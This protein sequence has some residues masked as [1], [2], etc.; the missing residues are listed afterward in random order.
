MVYANWIEVHQLNYDLENY[1]SNYRAS[2]FFWPQ[3][4]IKLLDIELTMQN[5]RC[6]ITTLVYKFHDFKNS[7][8]KYFDN[9]FLKKAIAHRM[10]RQRD[11]GCCRSF[12]TRLIFLLH[13]IVSLYMLYVNKNLFS[14]L[15]H[16]LLLFPLLLLFIES[17]FTL[18]LRKGKVCIY[19][20]S[21]FFYQ[22]SFL[23]ISW[24]VSFVESSTCRLISGF[25]NLPT[26]IRASKVRPWDRESLYQ[27][28]PAEM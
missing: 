6:E 25:S 4:V 12:I 7:Y 15:L 9:I 28:D 5:G 26:S 18:C 20:L 3:I 27:G 21:W 24:S 17:C 23:I 16:L 10:L 13:G 1:I 19:F 11:T 8:L 2:D 22:L 14:Q